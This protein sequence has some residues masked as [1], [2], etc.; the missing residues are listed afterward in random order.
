MAMGMDLA[1]TR[2]CLRG[3]ICP[4]SLRRYFDVV[5]TCSRLDSGEELPGLGLEHGD[6]ILGPR[7][8][9]H[10]VQRLEQVH[11]G[12]FHLIVLVV[13][14]DVSAPIAV[15]TPEAGEDLVPQQSL[16]RVRVLTR[17]PAFP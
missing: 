2:G 1:A 6:G 11:N 13:P 5:M 4:L 10:R 12:E 16:V 9:P 14:Q 3:T 17:C 8:G 15:N 7:E